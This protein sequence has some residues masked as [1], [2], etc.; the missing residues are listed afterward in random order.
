MD[1]NHQ[2]EKMGNMGGWKFFLNLD[3]WMT[4]SMMDD[5]DG[6]IVEWL[7]SDSI[8]SWNDD[9]FGWLDGW[10]AQK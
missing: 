9:S 1:W 2:P 10:T 3:D 5:A 4:V 8:H 6:I 7:L